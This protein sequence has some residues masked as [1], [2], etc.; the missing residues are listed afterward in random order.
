MPLLSGGK[1]GNSMRNGNTLRSARSQT[2]DP[3]RRGTRSAV[4]LASFTTLG[5]FA[6]ADSGQ[7]QSAVNGTW[8]NPARWTSNSVPNGPNDSALINA[9]GSSY[10]VTLN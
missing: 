2:I 7:W 9:T 5:G 4:I 8:N 1:I 3:R 6:Y 10:T